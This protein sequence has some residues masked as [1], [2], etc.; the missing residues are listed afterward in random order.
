MLLGVLGQEISVGSLPTTVQEQW[1]ADLAGTEDETVDDGTA[2]A[3]GSPGEVA[4]DPAYGDYLP[5]PRSMWHNVAFYANDQLR[6]RVAW[7]L[8][9]IY[10][11]SDVGYQNEG[12]WAEPW[13]AYYDIMVS[14]RRYVPRLN[15]QPIFISF[16]VLHYE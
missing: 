8:S 9:Q 5:T 12:R 4:N 16:G 11:V 3:C 1:L 15:C 13:G 10:V 7:G 14:H 2:L 6:Q